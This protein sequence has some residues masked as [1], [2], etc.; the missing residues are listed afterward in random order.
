METINIS[1]F[2]ISFSS[3]FA[4]IN[5]LGISPILL[6]ITEI[7]AYSI[8]WPVIESTTTP[9]ISQPVGLSLPWPPC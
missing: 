4:L 3:L 2:I 7:D 1:F 5:P 6:S 9:Y 8:A